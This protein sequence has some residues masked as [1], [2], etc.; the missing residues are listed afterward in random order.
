MYC[1]RCGNKINE[2]MKY[3]SKCGNYVG[4]ISGNGTSNNIGNNSINNTKT[5]YQPNNVNTARNNYQQN[6]VNTV[7]NNYQQNNVNRTGNNYKNNN[8]NYYNNYKQKSKSKNTGMIVGILIVIFAIIIVFIMLATVIIG[9]IIGRSIKSGNGSSTSGTTTSSTTKK[10]QGKTAI[11][12]ERT[13]KGLNIQSL[14]EAKEIIKKDSE[15]QKEGTTSDE[16]KRIENN[17]ISKY[18]ITAVNLGEIDVEFA[19]ELET[20]LANL[21]KEYPECK[22][23]LTNLTITNNSP[24]NGT[25]AYFQPVFPFTSEKTLTTRP[26]TIKTR[27]SLISKYFFNE[28]KLENVVQA[29]SSVGHFPPNATKYS[30][31]AHEFG[32]Y[33]SFIALLKE[34]DVNSITYIGNNVEY[35]TL[36]DITKDFKEGK[37]SLRMLNEAYNEYIKDTNDNISFDSWRGTISKYALAKDTWGKYIYDETIAEAFHDVYLNGNN[38]KDASKYIVKIL[39][40]KLRR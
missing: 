12:S 14:E 38:A 35:N 17:I 22:D 9:A 40:E 10:K 23:Y 2:N 30:P 25:I 29:S 31:L 15:E 32:H 3:C 16:V 37:F 24:Q 36:V 4:N 26:W 28:Q 27:I 18:N 33:V 39:K 34:Y 7:R 8:A 21:Y 1:G 6:N 11:D 5:N 19:K 20:V 13:Y